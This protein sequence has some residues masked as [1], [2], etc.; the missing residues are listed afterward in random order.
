MLHFASGV[1]LCLFIKLLKLNMIEPEGNEVFSNASDMFPVL[2]DFHRLRINIKNVSIL[3]VSLLLIFSFNDFSH[4][5]TADN[6][7][8]AMAC[9]CY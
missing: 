7:L 5:S 9:K 1:Y 4:F 3:C 8:D 6:E 2:T